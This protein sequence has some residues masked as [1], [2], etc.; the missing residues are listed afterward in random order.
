M[1]KVAFVGLGAQGRIGRFHGDQHNLAFE[2]AQCLL[3]HV[4]DQVAGRKLETIREFV[5]IKQYRSSKYL[6]RRYFTVNAKQVPISDNDGTSP[7]EKAAPGLEVKS[8]VGRQSKVEKDFLDDLDILEK[9]FAKMLAEN[10]K[11]KTEEETSLTEAKATPIT[12]GPP[13][14]ETKEKK[15]RTKS[16]KSSTR[17]SGAKKSITS[18]EKQE[19][20]SAASEKQEAKPV[21]PLTPEKKKSATPQVTAA[22]VLKSTANTQAVASNAPIT[23]P[24]IS[25]SLKDF[26]QTTKSSVVPEPSTEPP[27]AAAPAPV[28]KIPKPTPTPPPA[29]ASNGNGKGWV[30]EKTVLDDESMREIKRLQSALQELDDDMD[31]LDNERNWMVQ[32]DMDPSRF[33]HELR[34]ASQQRE[35]IFQRLEDARH[36][37]RRLAPSTL[38]LEKQIAEIDRSLVALNKEAVTMQRFGYKKE[39]EK[40]NGRIQQLSAKRAQLLERIA[41]AKKEGRAPEAETQEEMRLKADIAVLQAQLEDMNKELDFMKPRGLDTRLFEAEMAR[42]QETL[43]EMR[44]QLY[45]AKMGIRNFVSR[46]DLKR[47]IREVD[48]ELKRAQEEFGT[49]LRFQM[50]TAKPKAVISQLEERK[51]TL[52]EQLRQAEE[53]IPP[54]LR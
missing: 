7:P 39:A 3:A 34:E 4:N 19:A 13:T 51:R 11:V 38:S 24:I 36:G 6:S 40:N 30:G 2:S 48:L 44:L 9:E 27:A 33:E 21:P 31:R 35:V 10:T 12:V 25:P 52:Q 49:L 26:P 43:K 37:Y 50:S 28:D 53:R 1:A 41:E 18:A 29:A 46:L 42:T 14:K 23:S 17:L 5:C 45:E 8:S 32:H 16:A 47:E 22:S 15:T 20:S 54:H